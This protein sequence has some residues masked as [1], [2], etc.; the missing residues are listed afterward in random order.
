MT[1]LLTTVTVLVLLVLGLVGY[2]RDIRRGIL[3]IAGTLLGSSLVAFWGERWSQ[4]L[5]SRFNIT[6]IQTLTFT[7]N[8]VAFLLTVLLVGYGGGMLLGRGKDRS[9]F[10]RR[11]AGALLGLLNGILII[12]YVLRYATTDNP[13]F[14]AIVQ[15][16]TLARTFHDGLP[17]LFLAV[18]L[19]IGGF[20][21]V[22]SL[23]LFFGI[24]IPGITPAL[25]PE[26]APNGTPTKPPT[27]QD[28]QRNV[29]EKIER[30]M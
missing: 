11:L 29:L 10:Q 15:S 23:F 13:K 22:R 26:A 8:C 25:P 4:N 14:A 2:W 7:V 30:R 1:L 27:P 24:A 19:A 28:Y 3:A 12:A 16:V 17:W 6:T 20:V 9:T 5:A 18:T 21:I